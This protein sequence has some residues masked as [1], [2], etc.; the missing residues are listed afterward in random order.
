[1]NLVEN[2]KSLCDIIGMSIPKLEKELGFGR[3]SIYNWEKS[4]P[5]I[6][7]IEKVASYFN[8]SI[9]RI[10][11]GYDADK[12]SNLTNVARG[13]RTMTQFSEITGIDHNELIKICLGFKYD[14][15]S[16]DTVK[17]IASN[18]QHALLFGEDAFLEAAG[19]ASKQR[20]D[21]ARKRLYEELV[22]R[23]RDNGLYVVYDEDALDE[24]QI[25]GATWSSTDD[26]TLEE[27][28]EKGFDLL[29][30]Y[31]AEDFG[32]EPE[33]IAAHHDGEEWT[34]E[35][36]EEIERFK[37]FVKLKRQKKGD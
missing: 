35:E 37:E 14:R 26:Y 1:M 3:G 22:E 8:V 34:G 6:D 27:F 7:K 28:L 11:Y 29:D 4:S 23:Y 2:I 19:Y 13:D 21:S 16:L 18:N 9:N 30:R 25:S 31:I 12:F 32:D 5:S 33:T 20:L 24:I 36:L 17:K 10:L 15:P